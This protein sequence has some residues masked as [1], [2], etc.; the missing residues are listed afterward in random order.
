[1]LQLRGI[2]ASDKLLPKSDVES[3]SL[4][5]KLLINPRVSARGAVNL[6]YIGDRSTSPG[7]SLVDHSGNVTKNI[8]WAILSP[9]VISIEGELINERKLT[10][11]RLT[12]CLKLPKEKL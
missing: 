1:M 10:R 3:R 2:P 11:K 7:P 9:S 4:F 6:I 12:S 8:S 5:E